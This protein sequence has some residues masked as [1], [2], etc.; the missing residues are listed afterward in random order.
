MVSLVSSDN[1]R[2]D[3]YWMGVRDALRMVDSFNKWAKRNPYRAKS[4]EDFIHD[5]LIAAAKRCESCLREKLGL[6]F[7]MGEEEDSSFDDIPV[8]AEESG[9]FEVTPIFE[10]A[11]KIEEESAGFEVAPEYIEDEPVHLSEDSSFEMPIE[12]ESMDQETQS[13]LLAKESESSEVETPSIDS[14]ERL[15]DESL[16]DIDTDGPP[17]DFTTDFV[18]VEPTPLDVDEHDAELDSTEELTE[19]TMSDEEEKPT[20]ESIPEEEQDAPSFTWSDYERAVT[21]SSEPE[22]PDAEI[23]ILSPLE[24][25]SE[26]VAE[27]PEDAD[28]TEPPEPPKIWSPYDEPS[29]TEEDES[30][31][32]VEEEELE[33]EETDSAEDIEDESDVKGPP[34]PPPPESEEDEEERRRRARRLF[35][36]A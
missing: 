19:D 36:G 8:T 15:E 14:V 29:L 32:E 1:K 28:I 24:E 6:S 12:D 4:L 16:D 35:F 3:D 21:P 20:A 27:I 31:V 18:L 7:V 2:S 22:P 26:E 23:D 10:E 13:D 25:E 33:V 5:G 9:D 11:P 17:R 30:A 34:P